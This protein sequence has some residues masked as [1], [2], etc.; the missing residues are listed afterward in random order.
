LTCEGESDLENACLRG[1]GGPDGGKGDLDP[2]GKK[3]L[4]KR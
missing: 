1:E 4:G 2:S 3:G